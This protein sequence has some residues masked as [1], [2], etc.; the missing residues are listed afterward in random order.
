MIAFI[1]PLRSKA[2]TKDWP[3]VSK[4]CLR[5]LRSLLQQSDPAFHIF[6]VCNEPPEGLMSSDKLTVM[7]RD[8]PI[9]ENRAPRYGHDKLCK[10]CHGLIEAAS[11]N[12]SHYM[13]VD[14]DDLIHQRLVEHVEKRPLEIG[15][16]ADSGWLYSEGKMWMLYQRRQFH[17]IC[18]TSVVVPFDRG[19]LPKSRDEDFNPY[20]PYCEHNRIVDAC[21]AFGKK[22]K[23]LPFPAAVYCV[24]TWNYWA[25]PLEANRFK[26]LIKRIFLT[27]ALTPK[28][29]LEFGLDPIE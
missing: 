22:M 7:S 25:G 26:Y 14:A 21:L 19:Y 12:P 6:L 9:P 28:R 29:R 3:T 2:T 15:W 4:L 5:T 13:L 18:G 11:V 24:G 23:P 1:V 20:R 8:F 17:R 27:R 16:F 10:L